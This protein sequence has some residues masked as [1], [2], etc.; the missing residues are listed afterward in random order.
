MVKK[1]SLKLTHLAI[2]LQQCQLSSIVIIS[3][4]LHHP[5]TVPTSL[6]LKTRAAFSP[7]HFYVF[8]DMWCT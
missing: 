3:T 6:H 8:K 5:P 2:L 1:V 7:Q 4:G